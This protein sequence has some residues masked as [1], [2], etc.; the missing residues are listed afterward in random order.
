MLPSLLCYLLCYRDLKSANIVI[1]SNGQPRVTD[2]GL[3]KI[4]H[5]DS[6]LT[7]TVQ[8]LGTPAYMPPE[9]ASAKGDDVGPLADIYSLGAV[10]YCLLSGRPPF[11][12]ASVMDTLLQVLDSDP[13]PVRQL[14][15]TT[16]RDLE[17]ICAKCLNKDPT[18]RYSSA[19]ELSDDFSRF[20]ANDPIKAR[21]AGWIE[22]TSK[23]A[24]KQPTIA[25][26]LSTMPAWALGYLP[27]C[28]VARQVCAIIG[29]CKN[30][31]FRRMPLGRHRSDRWLC[32]RAHRSSKSSQ[33]LQCRP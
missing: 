21:P 9:Q 15:P 26:I 23:W 28:S 17:T 12:A 13:I 31:Q 5:D 1:E 7:G 6:G 14:V 30:G 22:R 27:K 3:A 2:F 8:I 11:Q 29:E 18:K 10:L 4:T 16:P 33:P 24:T 20:L 19:T 25:A 32:R